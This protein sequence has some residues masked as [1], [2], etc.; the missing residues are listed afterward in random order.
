MYVHSFKIF[1]DF[2][3]TNNFHFE[4]KKNRRKSLYI[5]IVDESSNT[6]DQSKRTYR[7]ES[8]V[9]DSRHRSNS[10]P[11]E[12]QSTMINFFPPRK[13]VTK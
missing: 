11:D 7:R 10:N 4:R 2:F 5:E 13:N 1:V 8:L 3:S 6:G 12:P 9:D